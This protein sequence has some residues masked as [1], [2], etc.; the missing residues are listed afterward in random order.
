MCTKILEFWIFEV[1]INGEKTHSRQKEQEL[2][3]RK[4]KERKARSREAA[5]IS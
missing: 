3:R 4:S 5:A 2:T 1:Y